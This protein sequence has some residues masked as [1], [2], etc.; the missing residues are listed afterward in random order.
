MNMPMIKTTRCNTSPFCFCFEN[1]Y[2]N[3][4]ILQQ[5]GCQW[6]PHV[7]RTGQTTDS[8]KSKLPTSV[9]NSVPVIHLYR[10]T[11]CGMCCWFVCVRLSVRP[12][13]TGLVKATTI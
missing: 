3:L 2:E 12:S 13:V 10:A 11:W 4:C 1:S 5:C 7:G 8:S 9:V 6:V